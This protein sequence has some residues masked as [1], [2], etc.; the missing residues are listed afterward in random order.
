MFRSY[1]TTILPLF[2]TTTS[3][4]ITLLWF[5]RITLL[6]ILTH[7]SILTI[8]FHDAL[9]PGKFCTDAL[10]QEIQTYC[11]DAIA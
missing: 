5:D 3:Y 6:Y 2:Y 11:K 8:S 10:A 4:H 9:A 7:Y 1:H